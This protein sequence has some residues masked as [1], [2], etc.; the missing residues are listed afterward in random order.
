MTSVYFPPIK[1]WDTTEANAVPRM[2]LH[3]VC[4]IPSFMIPITVFWPKYVDIDS[5]VVM[6]ATRHQERGILR[7]RFAQGPL[8]GPG[9]CSRTYY[10]EHCSEILKTDA[11][12]C[13]YF[14]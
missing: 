2:T 13:V 5:R 12:P 3:C 1:A 4:T 6:L 10:V 8:P 9:R 14:S 11:C 7:G